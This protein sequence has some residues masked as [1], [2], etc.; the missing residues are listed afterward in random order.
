MDVSPPD[1]RVCLTT[2]PAAADLAVLRAGMRRFECALV[3]GLADASQD[4]PLA[5]LARD[6]QGRVV[7]GI[8]ASVYWDGLDIALLW[9][10][11]R[12]RGHGLGSRLLARAEDFAHRRGAVV[13]FLKTVA[14]R[15][16][17]E[18]AGYHVY[19]ALEDRPIG[20]VLYHMKK[21]LDARPAG[22]HGTGS[23]SG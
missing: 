17:Y 4:V 11:E 1:A 14:A 6:G 3:P 9:V 23:G 8:E 21:R 15:R 19:G 20:T 22:S 12:W 16:F 13:A 5:V 2:A 18:R 7:G 10:E